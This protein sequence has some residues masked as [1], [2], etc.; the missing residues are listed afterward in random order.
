MENFVVTFANYN[1][2]VEMF[3]YNLRNS[4]NPFNPSTN[5][6]FSLPKDNEVNITLYNSLG[7]MVSVILNERL[8]KGEH[9]RKFTAPALP[10]G[11]YYYELRTEDYSITNRMVLNK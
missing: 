6:Y 4:P 11:V 7:Q 3:D 5:I 9:V 10:S 2:N 1:I 8:K